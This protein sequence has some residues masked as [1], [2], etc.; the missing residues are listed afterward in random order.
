MLFSSLKYIAVQPRLASVHIFYQNANGSVMARKYIR[1]CERGI[2]FIVARQ[3]W[4]WLTNGVNIH[5][6]WAYYAEM[7]YPLGE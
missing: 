4:Q 2:T 5:A 6:V 1:D 3:Q 7:I